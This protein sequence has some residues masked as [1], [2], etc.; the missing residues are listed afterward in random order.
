MFG[1]GRVWASWSNIFQLYMISCISSSFLTEE[2]GRKERKRGRKEVK[3]KERRKEK[4]NDKN[5]EGRKEG[6]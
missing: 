1:L 4:D 2:R 5:K 3:K 6:H